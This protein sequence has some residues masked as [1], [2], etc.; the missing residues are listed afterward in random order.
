M[1]IAVFAY[2]GRRYDFNFD[3]EDSSRLYCTEMVYRV[4]Q[5]KGDLRFETTR[6]GGRSA[7]TAD[8]LARHAL[9][10]PPGALEVI[11]LA[12]RGRGP[13]DWEAHIVTGPEARVALRQLMSVPMDSEDVR[14]E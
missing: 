3:F 2:V 13:K 14:N 11:A 7:F 1:L 5:G 4:L 9:Q 6:I 10:G 12:D 8:D